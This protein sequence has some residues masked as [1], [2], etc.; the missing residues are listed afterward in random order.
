[1][2][3]KCET[4]VQ[5]RYFAASN[6]ARGFY[7]RFDEIFVPRSLGKLYILKGGPGTGKS[8]FMNEC[9]SAAEQAGH[10]VEYF[11]CSSD[12]AS[13][14]GIIIDGI[15]AVVDGTPPH[16]VDPMYPGCVDSIINLG[17]FWNEKM[18]EEKRNDIISLCDEKKKWY[19][20]A[21]R[22]L[23]ASELVE[24]EIRRE[25][26]ELSD[27]P[28][29]RGA[30]NRLFSKIKP[31]TAF[32]KRLRLVNSVGMQG[33]YGFDTFIKKAKHN[34]YILDIAESAY[35]LLTEIYKKAVE[36]KLS[37]YVSYSPVS[38]DVIDSI[39]LPSQS[40]CFSVIK[41]KR[42]IGENDKLI[43]M[44]RFIDKKGLSQ[45]KGRIK[46]SLRCRDALV[47]EALSRL[48]EAKKAHFALEDIYVAAMDFERKEFMT[49][50][51]INKI[52]GYCENQK[53]VVK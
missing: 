21:Y 17:D 49:K 13:L 33:R 36:K 50:E 5:D 2:K 27:I 45:I 12:P 14:D 22:F 29:M 46:F 35:I 42:D 6:S 43:N 1:M 48:D 53:N 3:E 18:L 23:E 47:S 34:F 25:M 38:V 28:K 40:I 9:A 26:H 30:V 39:Y 24:S 8:R 19:R 4:G 15:C 16:S 41:S 10:K 31:G 32:E 20:D 44:A 37:V 11:Y 52:I 7:N 51:W